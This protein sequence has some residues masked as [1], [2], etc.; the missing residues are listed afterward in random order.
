MKRLVVFL[1]YDEKS[2]TVLRRV[3]QIKYLFDDVSIIY[4]PEVDSEALQRLSIPY[5]KI[6]SDSFLEYDD[7]AASP[8]KEFDELFV[9]TLLK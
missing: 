9:E 5:V 3:S 2:N 8:S 7:A 6:E 1:G 4:V